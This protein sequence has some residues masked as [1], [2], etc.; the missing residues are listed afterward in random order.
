MY[1]IS[2]HN[3]LGIVVLLVTRLEMIARQLPLAAERSKW[4]R[5]FLPDLPSSINKRVKLTR[6]TLVYAIVR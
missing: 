2:L 1:I 6:L 4:S 5:R 3:S